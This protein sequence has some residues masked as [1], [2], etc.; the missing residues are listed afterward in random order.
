MLVYALVRLVMSP[1]L[2]Q[3]A[4]HEEHIKR[5]EVLKP[6]LKR[7][8]DKVKHLPHSPGQLVAEGMAGAI[9]KKLQDFRHSEHLTDKYLMD[10]AEQELQRLRAPKLHVA[11]D[12]PAAAAPLTSGK[13]TGFMVLGMHRSGTSMLSGL[14]ATG[15]GYVTGG[16]LIGGT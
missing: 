4:P 14:M 6:V 2:T 16:P 10:A 13:R 9:R 12:A 3:E 1:R 11:N 7:A 8:V 15:M 5:G